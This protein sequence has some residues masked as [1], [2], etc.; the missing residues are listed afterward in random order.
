MT[1]YGALMWTIA[2]ALYCKVG[3]LKFRR[4]T[5]IAYIFK[6]LRIVMLLSFCFVHP[7]FFSE[8]S[9]VLWHMVLVNSFILDGIAGYIALY[10]IFFIFGVLTFSI[11]VLM[12]GLSAFLHALRLH[13]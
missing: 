12:E 3:C 1:T 7:L 11:L 2:A 13:W 5:Y 4:P 9:E 10:V 6:R 8:L